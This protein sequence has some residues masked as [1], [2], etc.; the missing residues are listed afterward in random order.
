MC[1]FVACLSNMTTDHA[2]F[3]RRSSVPTPNRHLQHLGAHDASSIY[4]T[5]SVSLSYPCPVSPSA[6]TIYLLGKR[7][8]SPYLLVYQ[9]LP[10][11]IR[12]IGGVGLSF[13]HSRSRKAM[14]PCIPTSR[15][16]T[17]SDF[18]RP[19]RHP[20]QR[21]RSAVRPWTSRAKGELHPAKDRL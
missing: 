8:F 21:A 9:T 10:C 12:L 2:S 18:H 4:Y 13:M 14:D 1:T 20:V 15:G 3:S 7:L 5:G 17:V 19:G 11:H 16:R 6:A